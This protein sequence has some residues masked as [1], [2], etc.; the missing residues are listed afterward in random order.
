M[1]IYEIIKVTLQIFFRNPIKEGNPVTKRKT[2]NEN[3]TI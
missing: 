2:E 3:S 1:G